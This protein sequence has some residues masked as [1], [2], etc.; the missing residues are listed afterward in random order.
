[1]DKNNFTGFIKDSDD[2]RAEYHA[3]RHLT[4]DENEEAE[5]KAEILLALC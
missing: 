5:T 2:P 1:M 4:S 3:W